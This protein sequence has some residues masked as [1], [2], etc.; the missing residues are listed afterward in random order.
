MRVVPRGY[1]DA[2]DSQPGDFPM[3][4][5]SGL[6]ALPLTESEKRA[7]RRRLRERIA[8]KRPPGFAPWPEECGKD[9]GRA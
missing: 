4:H 5:A 7:E 2:G 9:G 8:R 3:G 6:D 1:D